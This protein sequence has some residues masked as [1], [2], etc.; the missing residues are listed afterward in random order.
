MPK[1]FVFNDETVYNCYGFRIL[2]A[3]VSMDRFNQNPVMLD[4]HWNSNSSVLGA[5]RNIKLEGSTITGEPE[6]DTE[7]ANAAA[8][9]G[10]VERGF[11]KACSMGFLFDAANMLYEGQGKYVLTK[12]ELMEVSIVAV[13][14]N[15]NAVRL[16]AAGTNELMT[17]EQV[18]M[19]LSAIP[20]DDNPFSKQSNNTMK[21]IFLSIPALIALGLD[22]NYNPT[23][24]A[25]ASAV[26]AGI[27]ELQTKLQNSELKLS[28]TETALNAYKQKEEAA[29]NAE[30]TAFVNSVIPSKYD[31]TERETVTRL[32]KADL[33]FAKKIAATMPEKKPLSGTVNN[34][35]VQLA[36]EVKTMD[37]FQK[38]STQQQLA[39]RAEKPEAYAA[40]VASM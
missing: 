27:T 11:I 18:K 29:L 28:A 13:P 8:I 16:Y 3:G 9:A 21:K 40:L 23:E 33:A 32:A 12:C 6:F 39:F 24:G 38:L 4:H 35:G 1:P 37:E 14:G 5:W 22:K 17:D 10:K 25:D 19:C 26:E 7:D 15:A 2:S 34:S 30:V 20:T 31:E 36:G